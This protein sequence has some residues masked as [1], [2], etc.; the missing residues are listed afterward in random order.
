VIMASAMF[1]TSLF[2]VIFLAAVPL[3][4]QQPAQPSPPAGAVPPAEERAVV[5]GDP[6]RP[7][8]TIEL[9]AGPAPI[10]PESSVTGEVVGWEEGRNVS[11]RFADGSQVTYPVASNIIFPPDIRAGGRIT[12]TTVPIEGGGIKVT[13]LTTVM[14]TPPPAEAVRIEPAATPT[15]SGP[16]NIAQNSGPRKPTTTSL[17]AAAGSAARLSTQAT[18]TVVAYEKGKS[19]SLQRAD[20]STVTYRIAKSAQIPDDL[21]PGKQVSVET[22]VVKRTRYVTKVGY[23]ASGIV[24]TNTK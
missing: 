18:S 2:T 5:P 17:A 22:K 8:Q 4:A 11:V 15:V 23:K 10:G 7:N 13:G 24:I 20:G 9:R 3:A 16:K 6:G 21:V 19:L 14:A 1:R 12:V